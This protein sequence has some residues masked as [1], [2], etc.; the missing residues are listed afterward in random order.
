MGRLEGSHHG[1]HRCDTPGA[2]GTAGPTAAVAPESS[3]ADRPLGRVVRRRYAV[4][5]HARPQGL[6][7]LHELSTHAFG[8]RH[9]TRLP[10]LEPPLHRA[11]DRP[12]RAATARMRQGAVTHPRPPVQQLASLGPQ[13]FAARVGTAPMRDQGFEVPPPMR[14]TALPPPRGIPRIGAHGVTVDRPE[15]RPVAPMRGRRTSAMG[16]SNRGIPLRREGI[17]AGQELRP[18]QE[19]G[20][21]RV[22]RQGR[23]HAR[24]GEMGCRHR[25][26]LHQGLHRSEAP[27]AF[28]ATLR[29]R[30]DGRTDPG[31]QQASHF[32]RTLRLDDVCSTLHV[33]S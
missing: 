17:R 28:A 1:Q 5:A 23:R 14:P 7:P 26:S 32:A 2:L 12:P 10:R 13:R 24:S 31:C 33:L 16:S 6:A 20:W 22:R 3:W 30:E 25:G 8:L 21:C 18:H 27:A 4:M 19:P 29:G 9:A 11:P 15:G